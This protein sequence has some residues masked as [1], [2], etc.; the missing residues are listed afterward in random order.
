MS[1]GTTYIGGK[2]I[3]KLIAPL[4]RWAAPRVYGLGL[5]TV[6]RAGRALGVTPTTQAERLLAT[7]GGA[8]IRAASVRATVNAAAKREADDLARELT[9][10]KSVQEGV[11]GIHGTQAEA[12]KAELRNL[13]RRPTMARGDAEVGAVKLKLEDLDKRIKQAL[14]DEDATVVN[15]LRA[16]RKVLTDQLGSAPSVRHQA[17]ESAI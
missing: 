9:T 10:V 3:E 14:L 15:A 12:A 4:V 11:E 6:N 17:W 13:G 1:A 2:T 5:E 8:P 16:E 7:E